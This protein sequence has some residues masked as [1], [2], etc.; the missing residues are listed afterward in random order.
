MTSLQKNNI[1]NT[2]FEKKKTPGN[3]KGNFLISHTLLFL[4]IFFREMRLSIF[5]CVTIL[6]MLRKLITDH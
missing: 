1:V 2:P 3:K 5:Y 6:P 4:L